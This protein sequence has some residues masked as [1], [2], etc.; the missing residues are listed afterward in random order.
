MTVSAAA[1][2]T[3]AQFNCVDV[4]PRPAHRDGAV[5]AGG[6]EA[7]RAAGLQAA[8][9][10]QRRHRALVHAGQLGVYLRGGESR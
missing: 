8:H 9:R 4:S 6:D 2:A 7:V 5:R 1:Q 3:I 10:Q